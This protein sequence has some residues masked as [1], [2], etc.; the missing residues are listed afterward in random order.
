MNGAPDES[1]S[2]KKFLRHKPAMISFVV[3]MVYVAIAAAVILGDLV[4]V[5]DCE[6][7]YG[8][9]STP[10]F[11][12]NQLPEKELQ[13]ITWYAEQIEQKLK[14]R[15]KLKRRIESRGEQPR[16]E[17]IELELRG[18]RIGNLR[19]AD[20]SAEEFQLRLDDM[21]D[22]VAELDEFEDLN[23]AGPD[24]ATIEKLINTAA[25]QMQ[26]LYAEQSATDVRHRKLHL[27][28][29]TDVSGRSVF[30]R[31]IYSIRVAV[32]VGV[33]TGLVSVTFGSL[34]GL[35]AGYFGGWT[36]GIVTW[37]Y[38]TFASIPNIVLLMVLAYMF[39]GGEI[40]NWLNELTGDRFEWLIGGT[41]D[42]TLIPVFVAFSA[43]FWIGP[44]RIIRGET[45]KLRESEFVQAAQVMGY[46]RLRI[47]LRHILPNISHLML[48]NFSLLF[49]GAIKSEVILSFLG[50]G[51]Q[52][53]AS[54]G[55]MIDAA[56]DEVLNDFFWQIG[57]ATALMF[58][59]VLAFNILSDALQDILDPKHV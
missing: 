25:A 28:F 51:V 57:A 44:C 31:S 7:R 55:L 11:S 12:V 47:L 35:A 4:S 3:I 14:L 53:G 1:R 22:T 21:W 19:P 59:L 58:G 54:W 45:L 18:L 41:L 26:S 34:L 39:R 52:S 38:S 40:D 27:L 15:K 48:I 6:R 10:G 46:S 32:L 5:E 43:T 24:A 20:I 2:L 13:D 9:K 29:G 42:E 8:P 49:I 16:N 30:L 33:V 23:M 37:L 36:D 56:R 50:V 17:D